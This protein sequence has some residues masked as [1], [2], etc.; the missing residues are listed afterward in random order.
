MNIFVMPNFD[1]PNAVSCTL[2]VCNHL[3]GYGADILMSC[4]N[5]DKVSLDFVNYG[6]FDKLIA[7]ADI[8]IAIGGDGTIIDAAK[9]AVEY[10]IPLLGVNAGRLGFLAG[11][12]VSDLSLLRKLTENDFKIENRMMLEALLTSN[13]K[14]EIRYALNDVTVCKGT[15][16][17][18]ID[19]AVYC[20]ERQVTQTRADGM[21]FATP[22]GST[23]YTLSTGGPIVD[24]ILD[25]IM[26]TAICPHSLFARTMIFS[27]DKELTV[28]VDCD[29]T[30]DVYLIADG[31]PA[32]KVNQNDKLVIKKSDKYVKMINLHDKPF[33]QLINEKFL[34]RAKL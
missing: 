11:V 29:E 34:V 28:K 12:E 4:E 17:R 8:I 14:Q 25:S 16:S 9:H 20:N 33:Y 18:I 26:I 6:D 10:D 15:R 27:A 7:I 19:L 1:K 32:I 24:P 2:Q 22:T 5:K 3:N 23:A 30:Q 21:I 13:G 31:E